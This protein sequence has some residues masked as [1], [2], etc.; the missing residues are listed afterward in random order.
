VPTDRV[1]I[2]IVTAANMAGVEQAKTGMLGL[3]ASTLA[4]GASI[5]AALF[6][7]KS[8]IDNT[9]RMTKAHLELQQATGATKQNYDALQQTFDTWAESNKRYIPDQY[10]AEEAFAAFI[11]A[12]ADGPEAVRELGDALDLATI[13]GIDMAT[14]QQMIVLALAGNARGLKQLGITTDE[15]KAAVASSTTVEGQHAAVLALIET[16]IKG[17]RYAQDELQQ[18]TQSLNKDWQDIT[19]RIG[20]PLLSL[21]TA[22]VGWVD[23]L[24]KGLSDLGNNKDWNNAVSSGLGAIQDVLV[25]VV[26]GFEKV[27][28]FVQWLNENG[29]KLQSYLFGSGQQGGTGLRSARPKAAGGP[30]SAGESY[31]VGERGPELFTAG[32]SGVITPNG[33][34]GGTIHIHI[35]GIYAGDG[36]SLDALANRLAQRLGYATGR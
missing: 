14:S 13:K 3:N 35:D 31:L 19:T 2:E 21:F 25:T 17:G 4:L 11:R 29:G 22:I 16:R 9:E 28:N 34:L 36:P 1:L 10:A 33:A 6:I 18:S 8:A 7:G 15:Y 30:V 20:P 32:A 5:G 26:Q 23:Q 24:V 12:G 27:V